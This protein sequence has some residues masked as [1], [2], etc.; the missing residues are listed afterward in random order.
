MVALQTLKSINKN[1]AMTQSE[2][3]TGKSISSAKD[4]SAVW[5][6]SKVMESDVSGFK[7]ISESLSL[8][9]ASVAVGR[10]AA[11]TTTE[12]LKQM[13]EK[14][15]A[16]QEENVDRTKLQEDIDAL[17]D[18][19]NAVTGAAQF[20]G[21]NLVTGTEDVQVLASLD[22]TNDG[23]VK[24]S[25]ITVERQNL[26]TDAGVLGAGANLTGGGTLTGADASV[27]GDGVTLELNGNT[28]SDGVGN[29]NFSSTG[30]EIAI[31]LSAAVANN[32][33]I[34]LNIGNETI[35]FTATSN[36]IANEVA[37]LVLD[38]NGRGIEGILATDDG[39]GAF[40][41]TS[42]RG[43]EDVAVSADSTNA[44]TQFAAA[45]SDGDGGTTAVGAGGAL[46]TQTIEARASEVA[47]ASNKVVN[48]GDGYA[49][50]FGSN[51]F[52][53]VAGANETTED[54]AKGLKA[55][56]DERGLENIEV[57]AVSEG[58]EWKLQFD[59]S[60]ADLAVTLRGLAGGEA[61][62][63]MRAL[64]SI[65]VTTEKGATDALANIETLIDISIDAAASFGSVEGRIETQ[66][67]FISKMTDALTSGIGA[68]VDADMEEVS[69]RLQALQ[70]QQQLGVQ[71][72]SIANQAPQTILSLFR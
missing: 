39:A 33:V 15:V 41:I 45:V 38:I 31:T 53:Y 63:G 22:R 55:A 56:I 37:A 23:T 8:G 17:K 20:N 50:T 48:N 27:A 43:F 54:V 11:E 72:L 3:S 47:F 44:A 42:T 4:N 40:T 67:D 35:D 70:T 24:S 61:T 62:G 7:A 71:S 68:L 12:L 28:T 52:V 16:S 69:A 36:V 14:I 26:T 9:E 46:A 10:N 30:N 13:K 65:N 6:I 34:T 64:E 1:L 32:D 25:E 49:L 18:Q 21:L 58:G 60:G 29:R 57:R 66:S 2:I 59:N 5:A 19:I 51:E